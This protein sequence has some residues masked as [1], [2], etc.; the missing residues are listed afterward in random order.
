MKTIEYSDK[1]RYSIA[2]NFFMLQWWQ[3]VVLL[4]ADSVLCYALS[5]WYFEKRKETVVVSVVLSFK[6]HFFSCLQTE[7]LRMY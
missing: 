3:N 7:L 5:I 4:F 2:Y 6:D 1:M